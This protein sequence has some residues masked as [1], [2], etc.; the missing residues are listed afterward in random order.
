MREKRLRI[1][2]SDLEWR[3]LKREAEVQGLPL[4]TY[5]RRVLVS[6]GRGEAP[7][8]P[9]SGPYAAPVGGD[10]YTPPPHPTPKN[11]PTPPIGALTPR[12]KDQSRDYYDT[13]TLQYSGRKLSHK[14]SPRLLKGAIVTYIG[15]LPPVEVF[16]ARL[17]GYLGAKGG[18]DP[19]FVKA[20]HNWVGEE[21]WRVEQ[22]EPVDVASM[23]PARQAAHIRQLEERYG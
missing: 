21:M 15:E 14:V 16:A 2:L 17:K 23:D 22:M 9:L 7:V 13:V 12:E 4:A 6:H 10:I 11:P 8:R 3:A 20:A 5:A 19:K 18:E 1:W